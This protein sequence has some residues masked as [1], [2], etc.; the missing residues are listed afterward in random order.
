MLLP[1]LSHY[2][3]MK[4]VCTNGIIAILRME[5]IYSVSI[6]F[7]GNHENDSFSIIFTPS[8]NDSYYSPHQQY[9][10]SAIYHCCTI[11]YSILKIFLQFFLFLRNCIS[12]FDWQMK[13]NMPGFLYFPNYLLF[14]ASIAINCH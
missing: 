14:L 4:I 9:Y 13:K 6:Y 1:L 8:K 3:F 12:S 11:L 5:G 10:R 2:Y 7:D